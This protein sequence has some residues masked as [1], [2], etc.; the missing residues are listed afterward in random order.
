MLENIAPV[1]IQIYCEN[2][3]VHYENVDPGKKTENVDPAP[4]ENLVSE[5]QKNPE[6]MKHS[7]TADHWKSRLYRLALPP[8]MIRSPPS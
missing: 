6:N 4:E 5:N 7:E 2:D 8:E 1:G 3:I